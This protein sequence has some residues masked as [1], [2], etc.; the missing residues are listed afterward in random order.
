MA[1]KP[2]SIITE[3]VGDHSII[4]VE[5]FYPYQAEISSGLRSLLYLALATSSRGLPPAGRRITAVPALDENK[6][7]VRGSTAVAMKQ[8][9]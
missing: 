2:W 4:L 8:R 6:L 5:I 9:F 1:I 3:W 7:P